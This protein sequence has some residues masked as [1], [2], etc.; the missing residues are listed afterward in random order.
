MEASGGVGGAVTKLP[1]MNEDGW[2]GAL[3]MWALRRLLTAFHSFRSVLIAS[4]LRPL[5]T[6]GIESA[7]AC[8]MHSSSAAGISWTPWYRN[9][10][11]LWQSARAT[12]QASNTYPL[13]IV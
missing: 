7:S 3:S 2:E 8:T 11:A 5:A 4:A 6:R 12:R 1:D 10:S 9:M 13:A